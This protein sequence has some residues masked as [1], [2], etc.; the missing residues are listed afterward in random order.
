VG[1][2]GDAEVDDGIGLYRYRYVWSDTTYVGVIA[3]EVVA[4]KLEAV[5]RGDDGYMRVDYARLG[6]QLQT[7]DAW[8]AAQ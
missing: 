7:W 3:Q 1:F 8:L 2:K 4:V 6:L 5:Q